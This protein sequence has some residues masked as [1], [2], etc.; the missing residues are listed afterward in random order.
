MDSPVQGTKQ[1]GEGSNRKRNRDFLFT[2]SHLWGNIK[3]RLGKMSLLNPK[4]FWVGLLLAGGVMLGLGRAGETIPASELG[5]KGDL[6]YRKGEKSPFTGTAIAQRNGKK[7]NPNSAR[8]EW[9]VF[10]A[11]GMETVKLSPKPILIMG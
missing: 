9:M 2:K 7:K 8:D 10:T 11:V 4:M 3:D 6:F 5:R 1:R